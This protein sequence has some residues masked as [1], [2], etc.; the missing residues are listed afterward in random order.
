[1]F[2]PKPRSRVGADSGIPPEELSAA[3]SAP[4]TDQRPHPGLLE[5]SKLE[6]GTLEARSK[7]APGW[8]SGRESSPGIPPAVEQTPANE[9]SPQLESAAGPPPVFGGAAVPAPVLELTSAE[10]AGAEEKTSLPPLEEVTGKSPHPAGAR[11]VGRGKWLALGAG[12]LGVGLLLSA[13]AV[14][15]VRRVDDRPPPPG[16]PL[17]QPAAK[18]PVAIPIARPDVQPEPPAPV[19]PRD[20]SPVASDPTPMRQEAAAASPSSSVGESSSVPGWNRPPS[21][22]KDFWRHFRLAKR[23]TDR[24][25]FKFAAAEFRKALQLQPQSIEA[26]AGLG[27]SLVR[28]DPRASGYAEALTLLEESLATQRDNAQA[29]LALGMAYQFT[30]RDAEAVK[31]YKEFLLLEPQGSASNEVR[32]ML[33]QLVP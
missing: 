29:W 7:W 3:V 25:H 15:Q 4:P 28:S 24:E 14:V 2:A 23:A 31:A 8:A 10:M 17:A 9:R 11:R 26:K 1:M 32:A 21:P 22:E 33:K 6:L 27:I 20:A 16:I 18:A 19:A 12:L 13:I 5:L 30:R